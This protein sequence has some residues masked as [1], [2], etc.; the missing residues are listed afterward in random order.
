MSKDKINIKLEVCRDNTSGKL[1]IMAHFDAKAPNVIIDK[2]GYSWMPTIEEKNLLTEAFELI[3]PI[4]YTKPSTSN[5]YN[6]IKEEKPTPEP[7]IREETPTSLE[8]EPKTEEKPINNNDMPPL[9]KTNDEPVVFEVT[10]EKI[11]KDIDEKLGQEASKTTGSETTTTKEKEEGGEEKII[12]EADS[13]AI[14]AALKKHIEKDKD[15]S[16]VEVDEQ[17][18]IDKVLNQKKKGKWRR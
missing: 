8:T 11:E 17:T 2:N 14:E 3:T 5:T 16:F 12:V 15:D 7:A 4:S 18:I 13:E 6:T 1:T 10:E 9:E